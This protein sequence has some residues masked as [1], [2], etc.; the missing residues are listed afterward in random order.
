MNGSPYALQWAA[1][2]RIIAPSYDGSGSYV[3][4]GF[5]G[6]QSPHPNSI[7]IS[8]AVFAG[9]TDVTDRH[10][11]SQTET[12]TDRQRPCY[13]VG[14][15]QCSLKILQNFGHMEGFGCKSGNNVGKI[16]VC[17]DQSCSRLLQPE[18]GIITASYARTT[19]PKR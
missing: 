12:Q 11:D 4:H 5:L 8:S 9:L 19:E 7:S 14:L 1:P 3:I 16:H 13:V 15:L 6:H 17:I 18:S 2:S 10:T